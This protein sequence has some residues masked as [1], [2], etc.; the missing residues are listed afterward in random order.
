MAV[1]PGLFV[2]LTLNAAAFIR[3][4]QRAAASVDRMGRDINRHFDR[5]NRNVSLL[6][7]GF[8]GLTGGLAAG[9]GTAG[10][11]GL[12]NIA[13]G[14][15]EAA[16]NLTELAVQAGVSVVE[17]QKLEVAALGVGVNQ[18]QLVRSL[19]QFGIRVG[20]AAQGTGTLADTFARLGIS[21]RDSSG[22]VRGSVDLLAELA[23][24]VQAAASEQE[25]L[26]IVSDAFGA[27]IGAKLL[28]LLSQG[29][30]GFRE[31][32]DVATRA[33]LVL[34]EDFARKADSAAD[35]IQLLQF[36]IAKG[37]QIGFV[38]E[39]SGA[40]QITEETLKRATE[41][42]IQ[43]GSKMASALRTIIDTSGPVLEFLQRTFEEISKIVGFLDRID[44]ATGFG[45]TD[46]V[47]GKPQD[48]AATNQ[49][50][51]QLNITLTELIAKRRELAAVA[52]AQGIAPAETFAVQEAN[53]QIEATKKQI[54]AYQLQ[55]V[56]L[57]GVEDQTKPLVVTIDRYSSVIPEAVEG[58][59]QLADAQNGAASAA[60]FML[61]K[62]LALTDELGQIA[63]QVRENAAAAQRAAEQ[64]QTRKTI[65]RAD[66]MV[67]IAQQTSERAAK[68]QQDA[69]EEAAKQSQ[70]IWNNTIEGIQA[71]F[72]AA[73]R[74][75]FEGEITTV[76]EF[77]DSILG[78][79]QGVAAQIAA[80]AIFDLQKVKD[81]WNAM[82]QGQKT[83][84]AGA[85]GAVG[86]NII[87][88]A[89]FKRGF[90]Q[91]GATLGGGL[92]A[93]A[94]FGLGL[95]PLGGIAGGLLG[96]IGGGLL[97]GLFGR[98]GEDTG[99]LRF[100]TG[101]GSPFDIGAFGALKIGG[102]NTFAGPLREI[103]T[104]FDQGVSEFLTA[105]Q[106][107]MAEQAV[108]ALEEFEGRFPEADPSAGFLAILKERGAAILEAILPETADIEKI[109]EGVADIDQLG[110]RV[111][112][113]LQAIQTFNEL[114]GKT[115]TPAQQLE[116][117]VVGVRQ[118]FADLVPILR[119]LGYSEDELASAR[120]EAINLTKQA[121]AAEQ[122][123]IALEKQA[124]TLQL[125]GFI[126][127]NSLQ[128]TLVGIRIQFLQLRQAAIGLGVSLDLV[129][130][131]FHAAVAGARA[132]DKANRDAAARA[133]ADR[134]A[135]AAQQRAD[136]ARRRRDAAEQRAE[137][138][139]QRTLDRASFLNQLSAAGRGDLSP[140][141]QFAFGLKEINL[142]YIEAAHRARE[143]GVSLKL[144]RAARQRE[145]D[146]LRATTDALKAASVAAKALA[147]AERH[148]ARIRF[149]IDLRRFLPTTP[150]QE[151]E[152][153]LK[154]LN[155]QINEFRKNARAM[156][157]TVEQVND[158]WRQ[159]ARNLREEFIAELQAGIDDLASQAAGIRD[160]FNSLLDP[161][162]DFQRE[163]QGV[164]ASPAQTFQLAEQ[165]FARIRD[166]A[167][168]G[169]V[170]AIE[171]LD[172][173]GRALIEAAGTFGASPLVA[174]VTQ[175]V[176]TAV[177]Q[178]IEKT[179]G[180]R[181]DAMRGL[182]GAVERVGQEQVAELRHLVAEGRETRAA[183]AKLERQLQ[184][185]NTNTA[186]GRRVA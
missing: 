115:L 113:A 108:Q 148:V 24:K 5:V 135:A 138:R 83:F 32:M 131:A 89:F 109:F 14:S 112:V 41:A 76:Q 171:Q 111:Q 59:N 65:E 126:A 43:F 70:E 166:L 17:L 67:R 60:D 66:E 140:A 9:F 114:T 77:G 55:K 97:G 125:Q 74:S 25:R 56:A 157:F 145:I 29:A 90:G 141:Q 57:Q 142:R 37:F 117:A 62:Q 28:P 26:A 107:Q 2:D 50:I 48:L 79:F 179:E 54:Q 104:K 78:V 102:E 164:G 101:R 47:L 183:I 69:Q 58:T 185:I 182:Q 40:V 36:A 46:V 174:Q 91:E 146:D 80:L 92:G 169:N 18:E 184:Q 139:R 38:K 44:R 105:R 98:G 103:I 154:E 61:Q 51:E 8:R 94:G 16:G 168:G 124:L 6:T 122:Q 121:A 161:L 3:E 178:V 30:E 136:N 93:A 84:A 155:L 152:L 180:A 133:R 175:E 72:A 52:E 34:G 163:L 49:R 116:E 100:A 86:G 149:A 1:L 153:Q 167:L 119:T 68:A 33:G 129:D 177:A 42:A 11:A 123:A 127:G 132:A 134:S 181:D 137:E 151:L 162:L 158:I 19:A 130:Q 53:R 173:A 147:L 144:V 160:Q 170:A 85:A 81:F 73:F 128:Q 10:I 20:D 87:G 82:S 13:K 96:S 95:G 120:Q 159:A 156:G 88:G 110:Q 31:L 7:A 71:E 15:L 118:E 12:A 23:D 4:T 21:A 143:L 150:A 64:F 75:M 165:E 176:G 186:G 106:E 99:A 27:R 63:E 45:I 39:F 35:Q 22:Q 172:D